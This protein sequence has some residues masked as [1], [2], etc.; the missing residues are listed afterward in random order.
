[1][2]DERERV[3][4]LA[5]ELGD[6]MRSNAREMYEAGDTEDGEWRCRQWVGMEF[7]SI[8]EMLW[9]DQ[10]RDKTDALMDLIQNKMNKNPPGH[11]G[12]P[13]DAE[14]DDSADDGF[15][16]GAMRSWTFARLRNRIRTLL[17]ERKATRGE[18]DR[19]EEQLAREREHLKKKT[20]YHDQAYHALVVAGFPT[21]A[22]L[23]AC[24]CQTC[25]EIRA[26]MIDTGFLD[27]AKESP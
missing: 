22:D 5:L 23:N 9:R 6:G 10:E 4:A 26:V 2:A 8:A 13:P 16:D 7:A 17:E 20:R 12:A 18:C 11:T 3:R 27:P 19:L 24:G 25:E 15:H 14:G 21:H 1:M